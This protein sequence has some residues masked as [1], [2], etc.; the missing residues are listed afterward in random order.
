MIRRPPRSTLTDTLFPYTTLFR[1][2]GF[3]FLR[4]ADIRRRQANVHSAALPIMRE[5]RDA[6]D[7]TVVLSIRSG[8]FRVHIDLVE[9]VQPMR[10]TTDLGVGAPLYSGAASKVLLA[11]M[12]DGD[13]DDYLRRPP[14]TALTKPKIG[15]ESCRESEG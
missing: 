1:S 3:A 2:L 14:L 9:S 12:E 5:L 13:I 11:G 10:R 8:D 6:V 15:R 4:Y 7:E